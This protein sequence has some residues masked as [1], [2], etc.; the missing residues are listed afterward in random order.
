MRAARVGL[1][2]PVFRESLSSWT[3]HGFLSTKHSPACPHASSLASESDTWRR[4]AFSSRGRACCC[5]RVLPLAVA[6]I[7]HV[8]VTT[9]H[10]EGVRDMTQKWAESQVGELSRRAQAGA[11]ARGQLEPGTFMLTMIVKNEAR[12]LASSLPA[13]SLIHI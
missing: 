2:D 11:A 10:P 13:L 12:R 4:A 7:L 1:T 9:P 3:V 5:D 8:S 6:C